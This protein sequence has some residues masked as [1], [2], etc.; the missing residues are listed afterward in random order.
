MYSPDLARKL[1]FELE[2]LNV[3]VFRARAALSALGVVDAGRVIERR[4]LTRQLRLGTD[5][6][7]LPEQRDARTSTDG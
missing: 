2:R 3:E 1:S 7:V 5:R 4:A 6:F